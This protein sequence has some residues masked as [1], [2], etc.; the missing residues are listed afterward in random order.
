MS[1]QPDIAGQLSG[2]LL[3][4]DLTRPQLE[5]IARIF[6]E[7]MF[8]ANQRI[9]RQGFTGSNFYVIIDGQAIVRVDGTDRASLSKG[10]FFGELSIILGEPPTAD[11]VAVTPLRCL[12]LPGDQLRDFLMTYPAVMWRLVVGE[13]NRLRL[14]MLGPGGQT[15]S[16]G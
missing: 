3:F 5:A 6:E 11:V 4:A 9:L 12:S 16:A 15:V 8:D 2:L 7:V 10:D 14:A 1:M 13:A